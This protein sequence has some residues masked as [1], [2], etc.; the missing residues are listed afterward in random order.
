MLLALPAFAQDPQRGRL[1]YDTHC[2]A[3][4]SEKLHQRDKSVVKSMAELR[5]MVARWARQTKHAFTL[6]ELEDVVLHLN[7]SHYRLIK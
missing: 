3:C 6:D 5:D 4:H 7:Q 2:V 1:L